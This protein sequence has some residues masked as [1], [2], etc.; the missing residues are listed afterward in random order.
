MQRAIRVTASIFS[1]F[2]QLAIWVMSRIDKLRGTTIFP[3]AGTTPAQ[4]IEKLRH[5]GGIVPSLMVN[6]WIVLGFTDVQALLRD[7]R[8]S[9]EAA[10]NK[11]ANL[12]IRSAVDQPS[13][14]FFD[15]PSMQQVDP[16]EHSRLR[17]LTA[18]GFTHK[19]VQSLAP[20]IEQIADELLN[21][22][23]GNQFDVIEKL[24]RPLPAIVIAEMLG[25]PRE[26]RQRF[27]DW[28]ASILKFT[29]VLNPA[30]MRQAAKADVEL[31]D[32]LATLT[33]HKRENCGD[34]L[35]SELIAMEEQSD[36]LSLDELYS[37]CVLLLMAGHETTTRLVGSCLYLLLQHPDA[38]GEARASD[39]CLA[40]AIEESLR[41]EPP[42]LITSR[43]LKESFDFK[44]H[45]FK[46]GKILLLSILGANTD[47]KANPHAAAFDIHRSDRTHV[48]FGHG[49]HLCLGISLARLEAKIVFRK[50]FDRYPSIELKDDA[51]K[52]EPTPFFRGLT[53]LNVK[54]S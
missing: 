23:Q 5:K 27:E 49:I 2:V 11:F 48:S 38:M 6:G 19:F 41:L 47:P 10:S 7:D 1:K 18:E 53:E 8:V 13:I 44:G 40:N 3:S 25:V 4:Q 45:Q 39:E 15:H 37:T 9:A 35:I 42:V 12:V 29:D 26:D 33:A 17:K 52:W 30:G 54:V 24:A 32:Y 43:F 31:R 22:I 28:S 21:N 34:D 50:L 16:P 51:P 36:K 46:Q 20:T 14:P